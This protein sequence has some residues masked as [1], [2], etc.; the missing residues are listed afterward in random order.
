MTPEQRENLIIAAM[1]HAGHQLSEA[2]R[3]EIRR[4]VASGEKQARRFQQMM[5]SPTYQWK[6]PALRRG[7]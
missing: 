3:R 6:K 5:T 2:D 7:A 4:S 1:E